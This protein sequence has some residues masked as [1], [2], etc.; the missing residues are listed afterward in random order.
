[1]GTGKVAQF[2]FDFINSVSIIK[3]LPETRVR[4]MRKN[5]SRGP[6]LV[7]PIIFPSLGMKNDIRVPRKE[8]TLCSQLL[9]SWYKYWALVTFLVIKVF[10]NVWGQQNQNIKLAVRIVDCVLSPWL[11]AAW[12][13]A[14]VLHTCPLYTVYHVSR[15]WPGPSLAALPCQTCLMELAR[16]GE[17]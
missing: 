2:L 11:Y 1:M 15:D 10:M 12:L 5:Y 16:R 6:V 7:I 9:A 13:Y 3:F 4:E 14:A 17:V 8:A